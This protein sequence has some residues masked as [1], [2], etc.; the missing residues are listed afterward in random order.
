MGPFLSANLRGNTRP[1]AQLKM[2]YVAAYL[3]AALGGN[4]NPEA[5]DIKKILESVGIEADDTRLGKVI[6]ELKGKNVNEVIATG[7]SKLAS[8]PV[9]G[10]V[11][12]VASAAGAGSGGAAAP[13]AGL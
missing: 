7:Y 9:G 4:E 11:A 6:T 5:K 12:A 1:P 3:L 13:A 8:M 2:R 10:A